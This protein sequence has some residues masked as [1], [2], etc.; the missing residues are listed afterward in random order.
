MSGF[1]ILLRE[2]AERDFKKINPQYTQKIFKKIEALGHNPRPPG[3]QKLV[4][5]EKTYRIRIGD[6]RVLYQIDDKEKS[7]LISYVR[8]RKDVYRSR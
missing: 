4:S 2:S 6:Y 1:K 3:C 8:H 7:I 5:T